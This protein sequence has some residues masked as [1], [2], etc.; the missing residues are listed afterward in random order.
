MSLNEDTLAPE[1]N[2][3]AVDM[4]TG[5]VHDISMPEEAH[6]A[7]MQRRN[8]QL[9]EALDKATQL[10]HARFDA[11][12]K[13]EKQL[14]ESEAQVEKLEIDCAQLQDKFNASVEDKLRLADAVDAKNEAIEQRDVQI[15]ELEKKLLEANELKADL[16]HS[17]SR[18]LDAQAEIKRLRLTLKTTQSTVIAQ[19]AFISTYRPD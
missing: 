8:K 14:L 2:I 7:D 15:Q 10:N 3:K 5:V 16:A 19:S 1:Q 13:V 18:M 17:E 9:Q 12:R 4:D 11:L 6:I